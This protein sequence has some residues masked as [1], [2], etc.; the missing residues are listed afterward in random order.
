[1]KAESLY[2]QGHSYYEQA[3][4]GLAADCFRELCL[5]NPQDPQSWMALGTVLFA[6][7][8]FSEALNALKM[9]HFLK[10]DPEILFRTVECLLSMGQ[11]GEAQKALEQLE[12]ITNHSHPLRGRITVLQQQW[13][14]Q[15]QT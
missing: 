14:N 12:K 3:Q 2:A 10:P 5:S 1:M 15:W 13:G 11:K 9:A 4:W 8:S 7:E 6:A